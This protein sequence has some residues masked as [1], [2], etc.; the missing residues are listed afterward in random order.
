VHYEVVDPTDRAERGPIYPSLT[1]AMV[2]ASPRLEVWELADDATQTRT[3][4]CW[5]DPEF[6]PATDLTARR[7]ERIAREQVGRAEREATAILAAHNPV[8]PDKV[9]AIVTL[10]WASGFVAGFG[11]GGEQFVQVL[12]RLA[13]GEQE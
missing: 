6:Q 12:E 1:D 8:P 3:V 10:A 7:H 4:Q 5:P 2:N 13:G 11:A 9:H